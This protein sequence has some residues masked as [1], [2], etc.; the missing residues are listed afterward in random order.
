[1]TVLV[2]PADAHV[3]RVPDVDVL[4]EAGAVA[5]DN[6]ALLL[7]AGLGAERVDDRLRFRRVGHA[8]TVHQQGDN[9]KGQLCHTTGD[10][11]EAT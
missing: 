8:K 6:A 7:A 2:V 10:G 11:E 1:M 9:V 5:L 3:V 4:A